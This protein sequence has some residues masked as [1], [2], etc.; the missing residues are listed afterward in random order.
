MH[1]F[2]T[3]HWTNDACKKNITQCSNCGGFTMTN[4]T[5]RNAVKISAG[6]ALVGVAASAG[7]SNAESRT[8]E[9]SAINIQRIEI[10]EANGG[11]PAINIAPI[12]SLASVHEHIV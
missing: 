3:M 9:K 8:V 12:I 10:L 5:R 1:L 7:K 2:K 4:I 11:K 6:A